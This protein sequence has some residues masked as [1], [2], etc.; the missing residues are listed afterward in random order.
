MFL[1]LRLKIRNFFRK[2][3][4]VIIIVLFIWLIILIVNYLLGH[5]KQAEPSKVSYQPHE[6]VLR[7]DFDVPE[8][9]E[10]P[11]EDIIDDYI[12][13]CNNKDYSGA[14]SLLSDSCKKYVFDDSEENFKKYVDNIFNKKK[15]YS[16][17]DYSNYRSN[18]GAYYI[19]EVKIIDDIIATGLTNQEYAYYTEKWAIEKEGDKLKINVNDYMGHNELNRNGE[20]DNLKIR[21]E[22]RDEYYNYER[23]KIRITNKTEK[24]IILYDTI[25]EN[26]ITVGSDTDKRIP[27]KVSAQIRLIPEE[28]R[29]FYIIIPKFYDEANKANEFSFNNI[30]IMNDKYTGLEQ[31]V[32]E[33][34]EHTEKKYSMSISIQ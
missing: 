25:Y 27:T 4:S 29:T 12:S 31:T 3:R 1:E 26:E 24:N 13:K 34:D 33:E 15:R 16:I 10:T 2:H 9:L 7:S 14:Y 6:S 17:Q 11:I 20:D 19:Y 22:T 28:T 8:D 5:R 18:N 32:E 30:R 21:I 23:Y